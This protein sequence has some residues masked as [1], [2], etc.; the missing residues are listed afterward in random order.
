M[1]ST[2]NSNIS[3]L[4]EAGRS[5][6]TPPDDKKEKSLLKMPDQVHPQIWSQSGEIVSYSALEK[7][8]THGAF[9]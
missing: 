3:F 8:T 5:P 2:I 4:L 6:L 7:F 1:T 9:V